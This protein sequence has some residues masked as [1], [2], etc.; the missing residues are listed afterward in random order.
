VEQ[1]DGVGPGR[2]GRGGTRRRRSGAGDEHRT[3]AETVE[4]APA[5]QGSRPMKQRRLRTHTILR[6]A[7]TIAHD[8]DG[9]AY[10]RTRSMRENIN[11]FG[12]KGFHV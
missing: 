3:K 2:S 10:D 9:G 4:D 5:A 1:D 11:D 6:A 12:K 7:A 8:P